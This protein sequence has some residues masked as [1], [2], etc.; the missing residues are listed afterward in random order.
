MP[1]TG[2]RVRIHYTAR[3]ADGA[4]F[5]STRD[6]EPLEFTV[7]LREI[8]PGVDQTVLTMQEGESRTITVPPEEGFGVRVPGLEQTVDRRLLPED[9]TEGIPLRASIDGQEMTV[10]V[11]ELTEDTAVVD[12]NHPL[13]GETL[14]FDVELLEVVGA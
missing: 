5:D 13:A 12:P 4:T 6:R 3:L 7:G 9:T 10:W 14:T 8:L 1:T 11:T 2:D